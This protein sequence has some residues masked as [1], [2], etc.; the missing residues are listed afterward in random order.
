MKFATVLVAA[1]AAK[2]RQPA[3]EGDKAFSSMADA[4]TVCYD[5]AH[6]SV[7]YKNA[8]TCY[9]VN[10]MAMG[11]TAGGWTMETTDKDNWHYA[12]SVNPDV[13]GDNFKICHQHSGAL[14]E[15]QHGDSQNPNA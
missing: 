14:Y 7:A 13:I 8:C 3:H 5:Q 2:L 12:C 4:C 6:K 11:A 9:A 15:D 10:T 1:V